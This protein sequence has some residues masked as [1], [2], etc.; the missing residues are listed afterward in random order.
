MKEANKFVR[1]III[2]PKELRTNT[3]QT[4]LLY[5]GVNPD[6]T[7]LVKF[8]YDIINESNTCDYCVDFN[9]VRE[10][11]T[12]IAIVHSLASICGSSDKIYHS[13]IFIRDHVS[14]KRMI[15]DVIQIHFMFD[16]VRSVC[17]SGIQGNIS[18]IFRSSLFKSYKS[19]NIQPWK[20]N[21]TKGVWLHH[22][23]KNNIEKAT[24][25]CMF[26]VDN[27]IYNNMS[28]SVLRYFDK[29]HKTTQHKFNDLLLVL[30]LCHH[31]QKS[32]QSSQSI[33]RE[34]ISDIFEIKYTVVLSCPKQNKESTAIENQKTENTIKL[35]SINNHLQHI[36][37][38]ILR[39]Y[40]FHIELE[41]SLHE[42]DKNTIIICYDFNSVKDN[43]YRQLYIALIELAKDLSHK[44]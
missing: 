18:K 3:K 28:L 42:E 5:D 35:I 40:D 21:H 2:S 22:T 1:Q 10:K 19:V 26:I 38:N 44:N 34:H 25:R 43:S 13:K 16:Y 31:E 11:H 23:V 12:K 17:S 37:S 20:V 33:M 6:I 32:K 9:N 36:V 41:Y 8:I 29:L 4:L 15:H 30:P 7:L 24:A 27:E 39:K 14:K